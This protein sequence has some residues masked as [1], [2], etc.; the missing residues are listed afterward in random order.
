MAEL[1]AARAADP[2]ADRQDG[3]QAVVLH[4]AGDTSPALRSNY[5]VR[6][7]S[8]LRDEFLFLEDQL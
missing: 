2:K 4:G 5:Q 6:L 3:G 8:C 1:G 7:N